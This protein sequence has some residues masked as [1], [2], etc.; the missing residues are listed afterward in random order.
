MKKTTHLLVL[1]ACGTLPNCNTILPAPATSGGNGPVQAPASL[2]G[3]TISIQGGDTIR[4]KTATSGTVNSVAADSITYRPRGKKA[5]LSY[6]YMEGSG[7][8][9]TTYALSGNEN[10]EGPNPPATIT[11][12]SKKGN[13]YKGLL[14][15]Y[16]IDGGWQTTHAAYKNTP[17]TITVKSQN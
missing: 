5:D 2:A 10:Y 8:R 1:A 6:A 3:A 9:I 15:G 11:F 13:T 16:L 14:N 12:T 4:M 7:R 17:V